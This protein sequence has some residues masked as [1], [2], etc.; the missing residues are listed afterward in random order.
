MK[1][2]ERNE[3]IKVTEIIL[4]RSSTKSRITTKI[5]N[6][7]DKM[8]HHNKDIKETLFHIS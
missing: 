3:N 8:K 2:I 4:K 5:L 1:R 7:V 6:Q